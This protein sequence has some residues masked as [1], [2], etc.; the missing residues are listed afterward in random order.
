ML[1]KVYLNTNWNTWWFTVQHALVS[2]TCKTTR[3]NMTLAVD[4]DVKQ[5]INKQTN[6]NWSLTKG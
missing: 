1:F 3:R 4:R 6:T 5:Q 2:S